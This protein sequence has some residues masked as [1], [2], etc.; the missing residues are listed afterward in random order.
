MTI[1]K[2]TIYVNEL[3]EVNLDYLIKKVDYE[4]LENAFTLIWNTFLEFVSPYYTREGIDTFK[5]N[6][7][8][9]NDFK[10]SFRNGKQVMYGAYLEEKILG[11]V[12]IS[13]N[14]NISCFFVDKDYHRKGIATRL[15]KEVIR[16]LN[17]REIKRITLNSSPYAVL[18]YHAIGFR[19]LEKEKDFKGILYTPME[20]LLTKNHL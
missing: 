11:V 12:S 19:D 3:E 5:S 8:E 10:N 17:Y 18:F 14:N 4:G 6:F 13:S 9:S 20:F 15:F 2:I 16:E 1:F 7:I